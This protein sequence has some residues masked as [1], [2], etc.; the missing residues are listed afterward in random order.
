MLAEGYAALGHHVTGVDPAPAMLDVA[1]GKPMAAQISYQQST[2]QAFHSNQRFDLIIMTG[3]AFQ[4]LLTDADIAAT[5]ATMR[6]HLAAGG[7]IVFESRNPGFDWVT[8][9]NTDARYVLDGLPVQ[10]SRRM[11]SASG[12]LI[13]FDTEYLINGTSRKSSS[14]LQFLSVSDVTARLTK[15]GL[16]VLDLFGDWRSGPFTPAASAEMIFV[17]GHATR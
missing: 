5:F 6:D 10:E 4:V 14:T 9:W 2:A 12:N 15:A 16:Q 11:V 7:R 3:H 8:I 1:R 13:S 17:A